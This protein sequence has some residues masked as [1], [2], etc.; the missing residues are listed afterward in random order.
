MNNLTYEAAISRLEE[1]VN[2][3]E[4]NEISLDESIKLFEEGI[5]LT[6]Y[7]SNTLKNAQQ[8]I[9]TLSKEQL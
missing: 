5:E 2:L 8:K 1:I 6:A 7:C 4:K 3:L 9:T